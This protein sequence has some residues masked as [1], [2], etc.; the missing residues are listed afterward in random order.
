MTMDKASGM[1]AIDELDGLELEG[2][3]I[4]VNEAQGPKKPK[5]QYNRND[6]DDD[7]YN[8]SGDSEPNSGFY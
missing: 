5:P 1:D 4:R 3:F 2:R 8:D 6:D 7:W